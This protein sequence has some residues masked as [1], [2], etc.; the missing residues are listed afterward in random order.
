MR[1]A[2]RAIAGESAAIKMS[3]LVTH[4][5]AGLPAPDYYFFSNFRSDPRRAPK[6]RGRTFT[7][8]G[9]IKRPPA[10]DERRWPIVTN[11]ASPRYFYGEI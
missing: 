5:T 2:A 10:G 9:P 1:G 3:D 6:K 11:K 7:D 4:I 8:G